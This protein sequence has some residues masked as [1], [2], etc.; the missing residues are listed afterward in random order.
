[1]KLEKAISF[2][3][4]CIFSFAL[5]LASTACLVTAFSLTVD[6]GQLA[7]CCACASVV[8]SACYIL[9]LGLVPISAAALLGGFLWQSGNLELT[10][11]SLLYRLTRQY[12]MAYG[13]GVARWTMRTSDDMELTLQLGLCIIGVLIA[14][15]IAWGVCRRKTVLPGVGLCLLCLGACVVVTDTVPQLGWLFL[16]ILG[17]VMLLLTHTVRRQDEAQGNRLSTLAILPVVILL[18]LLFLA[19][20]Q[21]T[22]SGQAT[23]KA[24][25]DGILHA[26]FVE[27]L[28]G[29][30]AET[31]TTGSSV[32]GGTV[33]LDAV[34]VRLNS[35]A[36]VLKLQATYSGRLYLRGRAL[37]TYDGKSWTDSGESTDALYWPDKQS[38]T[39]G[40]EVIMTTKYAHRM[41][42]LPYYVTS[43]DLTDMTRGLENKKKLKQ[44]S[45]TC[46]LMPD[47]SYLEYMSD[48]SW[49]TGAAYD[50]YIHLTDE[51]KQ[52]AQPLAEQI[53]EGI[54]DPYLQAQAIG[55]YVRGSAAYDTNTWKMP[56]SEKDF[57]RWFLEDSATG[58]CVHFATSATVL[59]QAA[60]I[61][62]RYVTGYAV[63]SN[64]GYM[65]VVRAQDAHA[66][67]EYWLPGFGWTIL[68]A[69]PAGDDTAQTATE[70][71]QEAQD[72]TASTEPENTAATQPAQTRP[73]QSGT[74]SRQPAK[75]NIDLLPWLWTI[76]GIFL[77]VAAVILQRRL[78]LT[79]RQKRLWAG[80]TNQQALAHWQEAVRLSRL[81]KQE[82]DKD[83]LTLAQRAK[84]SQHTI[85]PQELARFEDYIARAHAKLRCRS[86][87]HQFY[88][89]ILLALY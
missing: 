85:T 64:R 41:L 35:S 39:P 11:E 26:D 48:D 22:Y 42:Y 43:T 2:V 56:S 76:L 15:A 71:T 84:F 55:D 21:K 51:V 38:L 74:Q 9:P 61:P 19:S 88:Y 40:G 33:Q 70:T 49:R 57:A 3:W 66:W 27:S 31:G 81:L 53:I 34:G 16:L 67:A 54:H 8:C 52:W 79:L 80:D 44:Y 86:L 6:M 14:M 36:E 12:N 17:I 4:S 60:G 20:P 58:Y 37:D 1:M 59:L 10:V 78:R 23:A 89:R 63:D 69:T 72:T 29:R 45:F 50:R 13:W 87:F 65:T 32:D 82:I 28:F 24:M 62:A 25:V 75:T 7:L 5:S 68:E 77:A 30:F 83:L 18:G 46:A 73:D 47:D